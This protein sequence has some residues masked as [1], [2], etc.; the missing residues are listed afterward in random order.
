MGCCVE[1]IGRRFVERRLTKLVVL[2]VHERVSISVHRLL[3]VLSGL[4]LLLWGLHVEVLGV[5]HLRVVELRLRCTLLLV[6]ARGELGLLELLARD[7]LLRDLWE[8]YGLLVLR[9][10]FL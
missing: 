1:Y 9:D 10:E 5:E 4:E 2:L 3:A 8:V 6:G 7:E